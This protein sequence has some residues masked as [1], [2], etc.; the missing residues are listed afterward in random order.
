VYTTFVAGFVP[1]LDDPRDVED[2]RAAPGS[3]EIL[4]RELEAAK[5]GVILD[6][7]GSLKNRSILSYPILK[8]LVVRD[9]CR[10]MA[11]V[12]GP[13]VWV[14]RDLAPCAHLRR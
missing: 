8:E 7:A 5:P 3:R 1:F 11:N 9:Y 2:E 12:G 14:R 10:V 6:S 13:N 4:R